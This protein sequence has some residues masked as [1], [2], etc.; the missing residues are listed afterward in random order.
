MTPNS[1]SKELVITREI[2]PPRELVYQ[3]WTEA[4]HLKGTERV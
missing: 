4:E 3:V 1:E 2:H